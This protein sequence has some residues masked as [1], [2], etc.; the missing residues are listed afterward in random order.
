MQYARGHISRGNRRIPRTDRNVTLL[1]R[2]DAFLR[3]YVHAVTL[4]S[5]LPVGVSTG[6]KDDDTTSLD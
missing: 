3:N 6:T 2:D 1:Y 5:L 4:W